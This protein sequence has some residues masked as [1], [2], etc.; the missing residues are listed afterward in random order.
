MR[1]SGIRSSHEGTD[2]E[3]HRKEEVKKWLGATDASS[4]FHHLVFGS[5]R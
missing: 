2:P 1:G 3:I 5:Y 4:H